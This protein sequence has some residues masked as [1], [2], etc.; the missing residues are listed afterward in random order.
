MRAE[1]DVQC[2]IE[3]E[4]KHARNEIFKRYEPHSRA[5]RSKCVDDDA[6]HVAR[7]RKEHSERA[8]TA[9]ALILE[10][11]N[12]PLERVCRKR[13]QREKRE[14]IGKVPGRGKNA[15]AEERY[16][17]G[18]KARE[19]RRKGYN[20]YYFAEFFHIQLLYTVWLKTP[21]IK[22]LIISSSFRNYYT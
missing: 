2:L 16:H 21:Y 3:N 7:N 9:P 20:S 12:E 15:F 13:Q 19:K 5:C 10:F 14:R 18:G 1:L 17:R 8:L 4:Y 6:E 11:R 22:I